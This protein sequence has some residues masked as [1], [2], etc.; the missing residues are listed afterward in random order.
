MSSKLRVI[1]PIFLI[2]V[3]VFVVGFFWTVTLQAEAQGEA[4]PTPIPSSSTFT[5]DWYLLTTYEEWDF[6]YFQPNT[7]EGNAE[8][9]LEESEFASNYPFGFTFSTTAQSSK[10]EIVEASVIWSHTPHDLIRR[11]AEVNPRTGEISFEWGVNDSLPPWVAVN[12]YWSLTDSAGNRYRSPWILGNEYFDANHEWE[13]FESP[14]VIVFIEEGLPTESANLTLQAMAEQ[15]GTY[16]GAWGGGLSYKPRVILFADRDDFAEWR[17]DFGG[18]G[19]VGQTSEEWGA[20]VQVITDDSLAN[21]IYGTVLHEVGHLYQFEYAP[22]A[23][24]AG[25]WFTEGNATFFELSQEY[26]YEERVRDLAEAG[27]LPRLLQGDGPN[28]FEAGPDEEGRLGYDVGYTFWRWLVMKYGLEAHYEIVQGV[29]AGENRNAVLERVT[30]M[31]I[32]EIE[33]EWR[34]WLGAEGS[35]ATLVPTPTLIPF[36]PTVTPFI[37]P[38]KAAE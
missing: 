32:M 18:S 25:S 16:L 10:G 20:T 8:W 27:D 7:S 14:D 3:V 13:R 11:P 22:D 1:I 31:S 21:L 5:E 4:T 6:P 36:P 23:F 28:P 12:Y 30:G 15:H 2:S 17:G 35:F 26:D 9:T 38:T 34:D 37:F 29:A 19:V 24:P 33:L